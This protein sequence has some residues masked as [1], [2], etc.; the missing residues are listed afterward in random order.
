MLNTIHG[1]PVELYNNEMKGVPQ[2]AWE[3]FGK[4]K[5]SVLRIQKDSFAMAENVFSENVLALEKLAFGE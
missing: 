2:I 1:K 3:E 4:D 5:S